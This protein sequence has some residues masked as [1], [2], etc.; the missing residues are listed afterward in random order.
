[1]SFKENKY[2]VIR[3]AISCDLANFLYNYIMT[4]RDV[5]KRIAVEGELSQDIGDIIGRIN[6]LNETWSWDDPQAPDSYCF[7][8]DIAMETLMIKVKYLCEKVVGEQLHPTY[9]YGRIYKENDVLA[10][11]KDRGE[12]EISA[13]MFLGG[14]NWDIYIEPDE[15]IDLN[16]GDMMVYA[17]SKL[18]HWRNKFEGTDCAQV[19]L[20][21]HRVS[22]EYARPFD[23]R[24]QIGLPAGY[25]GTIYGL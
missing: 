22:N 19:F 3:G 14:Q 2:E 24:G 13:T 21:Y 6:V 25:R 9:S 16:V 8:S 17:G 15:R 10:P 1:M 4:K 18:E 11:H 5:A 7:Y 23:G 20:H 12:C